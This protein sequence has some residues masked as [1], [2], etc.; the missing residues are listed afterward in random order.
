MDGGEG[1]LGRGFG[2]VIGEELFES[3]IEE[4]QRGDVREGE[5]GSDGGSFVLENFELVSGELGGLFAEVLAEGEGEGRFVNWFEL[6]T[7]A[8]KF[9]ADVFALNA[10]RD[11]S[12]EELEGKGDEWCVLAAE[13]CGGLIGVGGAVLE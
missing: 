5:D 12:V 7:E 4:C 8:D 13:D 1:E 9:L 6:F 2:I 11:A 10:T 3:L